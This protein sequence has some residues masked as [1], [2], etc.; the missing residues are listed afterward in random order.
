[1]DIQPVNLLS[2]PFIRNVALFK[3]TCNY[4]LIVDQNLIACYCDCRLCITP[5]DPWRHGSKTSQLR[6]SIRSNLDTRL[7]IQ[8]HLRLSE[9]I[10]TRL[11]SPRVP[12]R[13]GCLRTMFLYYP[14]CKSWQNERPER[15][16]RN[17]WRGI[18][19]ILCC[20]GVWNLIISSGR[21]HTMAWESSQFPNLLWFWLGVWG[22][23]KR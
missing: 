8:L 18:F 6:A 9:W 22:C 14:H 1:M 21:K 2:L 19:H 16:A 4:L 12:F 5:W 7:R 10:L 17:S 11:K 20:L 23:W 3:C 15:N 13:R